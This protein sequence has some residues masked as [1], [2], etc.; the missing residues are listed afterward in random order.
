MTLYDT[1]H[2]P[3]KSS[4]GP[5]LVFLTFFMPHLTYNAR[6]AK[7]TY[8]ENSEKM[9]EKRGGIIYY[10]QVHDKFWMIT[11]KLYGTK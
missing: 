5:Y 6:N 1:D 3:P 4:L 2:G 9:A 11:L 8:H 10:I 7:S